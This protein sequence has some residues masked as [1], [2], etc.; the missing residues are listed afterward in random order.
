MTNRFL[1]HVLGLFLLVFADLHCHADNGYRLWLRY[2]KIDD[3]YAES[4]KAMFQTVCI[5]GDSP[6]IRAAN[7]ELE[8]GLSGLLGQKIH[9]SNIPGA[10]TRVVISKIDDLPPVYRTLFKK[11][12]PQLQK[13]GFLI[14]DFGKREGTTLFI[15][16]KDDVGVLYGTFHLLRTVQ[17]CE[18][19]N[20]I[21]QVHTPKLHWRM[22]NHWDNLNGTIERGYA[23]LSIW[24]WDELPD[25][26]DNR[27]IDYARANASIGI[28]GV[29]LNNV[30]ASPH[31]LSSEYV[32]KVA[33]LADIFRPYGIRV[34]ISIN[35]A[36][37]KVLG[38][39]QTADPL[40]SEVKNW[41]KERIA[42]IYQ[43]IPDFGGFLVKANSE[44]QPGPQDYGR[45]HADGANM[46]AELL[47]PHQ[48]ILVWRAFVYETHNQDRVKD[49]YDEFVRF[50]GKFLP[51]VM[52]QT[53]NGPLDFQPREPFSP[54]FGAM[55]NT[56]QMMEFQITQEYLGFS[57]H[58][59]YLPSLYKEV[60][61][62]DTYAEGIGS[63][64]GRV[65]DG[66][67]QG[68]PL[69]G[70]AGVAN[71]GDAMNWTGHP[72]GQA[73]WYAY[74][75]LAWDHHLDI[76]QLAEEWI[77]MTLTSDTVAISIIK[78]MMLT[79]HG[80][81]V[82]YQTPLGLTVL[83]SIGHHYGPQPWARNSFHKADSIGVG[84]DRSTSGS[85]AVEQYFPIVRDSF[86]NMDSCPEK[87]KAWF[88]H[89]PWDYVMQ[90]GRTFWEELCFSYYEGVEGVREMQR[91]W[92]SVQ[93]SIDPSLHDRVKKLLTIQEDEAVWWR[94]ACLWYFN[95]FSKKIIPSYYEKPRYLESDF[96]R[97]ELE[98]KNIKHYSVGYPE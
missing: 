21:N 33:A 98:S 68:Q 84:F 54:L 38:K 14:R 59:V 16:G 42:A 53:K 83:S 36:S 87:Y 86:D 49:A 23:G 63:T 6:T 65:I 11:E 60:L 57:T 32:K 88:H 81:L 19:L 29:V 43:H 47:A 67:L 77:R 48:G 70:M 89:V 82:D 79:S 71:I 93:K 4:Y 75:R 74:G 76:G 37:P 55:R 69:T 28:N 91:E 40:N 13:E 10:K 7:K 2:E 62:S 22:L 50:D 39:L 41:W 27:Y 3:K 34:F 58:L 96:K 12:L 44:G 64:V 97:K 1:Y 24:K 5:L 18:K 26:I 9:F 78:N 66:S 25:K 94:D 15:I 31:I 85:R 8:A 61:E 51:N 20:E 90:S 56:S 72:F 35:F 95:K 46:L 17:T 30:N 45:T 52:L 92:E 73:N 80:H